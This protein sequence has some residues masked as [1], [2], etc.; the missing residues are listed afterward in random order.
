MSWDMPNCASR[1]S[2]HSENNM[3][4]MILSNSWAGLR[5]LEG[6]REVSESSESVEGLSFQADLAGSF[7]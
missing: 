4:A 3:T 2:V 7:L 6:C 5:G 1:V